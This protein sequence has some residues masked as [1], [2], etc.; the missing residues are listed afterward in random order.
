MFKGSPALLPK[1]SEVLILD[2]LEVVERLAKTTK[3]RN[4]KQ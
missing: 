3:T 4:D 2:V 1:L